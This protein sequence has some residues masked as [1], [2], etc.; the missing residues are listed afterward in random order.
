MDK[1][2]GGVSKIFVEIFYCLTMP[3]NLIGQPLSVSEIS[4]IENFDASEGYVRIFC[5]KFSVSQHR[6]FS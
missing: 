5:R 6:N 2:G 3:K 4:G 1:K